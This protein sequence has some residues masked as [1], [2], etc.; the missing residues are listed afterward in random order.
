MEASNSSR[1]LGKPNLPN[2]VVKND[3]ESILFLRKP[4]GYRNPTF[5]QEKLSRI[6]TAEYI[7]LFSPVWTDVP[8]QI[9]GQHPAPYPIEIPTR[10]IRMFS[11]VGDTVLD[12]FCGTGTTAVAAA[13]TV[14]KSISVDI[15]PNYVAMA[16][17]R[18]GKAIAARA[19]SAQ[20]G[21]LGAKQQAA[22]MA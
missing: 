7:R 18:L 17:R 15:D 16:A 11:F 4:G 6:P 13:T 1:F 21:R 2:G 8:G 3:M 19:A 9:R 14:R 22:A 10:I 20:P 12:P 5:R